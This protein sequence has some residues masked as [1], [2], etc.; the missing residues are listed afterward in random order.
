LIRRPC[1]DERVLRERR[2][3]LGEAERVAL[4]AHLAGC[5][6]CRLALEIGRAF[7]R[8]DEPEIDDGARI[9]RLARSAE[10]WA[11][12][13][14]VSRPRAWRLPRRRIAVLLA[15]CA[16]LVGGAAAAALGSHEWLSSIGLARFHR[17]PPAD[18]PAAHPAPVSVAADRVAP[19]AAARTGDE[20]DER[21]ERDEHLAPATPSLRAARRPAASPDTAAS[22]FRAASDARR[23]GDAR[24]AAAL[25][26]RLQRLFPDSPEAEFS[27]VSLG[28]LWLDEGR[29]S[30]ALDQFDR[31]ARLSGS[32]LR[33]EALYGRARA[34]AALHR[35]GDEQAAWRQLLQE[36]PTCPYAETARRRLTALA[37]SAAAA[38]SAAP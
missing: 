30:A 25:Y 38:E 2:G 19:T 14:R 22:L 11:R 8:F 36:F 5:E 27:H 35:D 37:R 3:A 26:R 29:L 15:A 4:D 31:A 21:D 7:D 13:G 17:P 10:Q 32:P 23:D 1:T 33:P 28:G 20:R 34:L 18:E 24:A 9:Q 6:S 12:R 16:V